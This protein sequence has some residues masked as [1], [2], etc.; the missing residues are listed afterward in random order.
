M[1]YFFHLKLFQSNWNN[2]VM[3]SNKKFAMENVLLVQTIC[4]F[5]ALYICFKILKLKT[6]YKLSIMLILLEIMI[7][8]CCVGGIEFMR[9]IQLIVASYQTQYMV[10]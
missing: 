6:L 3:N 5:L 9:G 4:A 8:K 7:A 2:K 1:L 10:V